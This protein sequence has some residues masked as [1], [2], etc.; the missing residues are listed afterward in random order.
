MKEKNLTM[1]DIGNA[2]G[3]S[4]TTVD[5]VL[6]GKGQVSPSARARVEK[7]LAE[8]HYEPNR[9]ASAL[10]YNKAFDVAVLIPEHKVDTYYQYIEDGIKDAHKQ[11]DYTNINLCFYKGGVRITVSRVKEKIIIFSP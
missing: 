10:S 8:L 9:Y 5:R 1:T 3:V 2:A 4:R 11:N 7:T 6:K